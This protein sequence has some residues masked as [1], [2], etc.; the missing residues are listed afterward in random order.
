VDNLILTGPTGSQV[1][2]G[3]YVQAD[4]GPDF[5]T[6]AVLK[7]QFV[8]HPALEGG[9]L[10]YE[11]SGVRR[12]KFP[13]IVPSQS[14]FA[15][16]L[17]GFTSILRQ[18]ARPGA[19]ID[20]QLQGTPTADAVRFDVI[21]GRLDEAYKVGENRAAVRLGTL[22]LDVQ[23]FG[24]WPTWIT[25]ASAASIGTFG[26]LA[27]PGASIL[28]DYLGWAKLD[29]V[30]T[31][32]TY[33]SNAS[34]PQ[35]P[36]TVDVAAWSLAGRSSFNPFLGPGSWM[37]ALPTQSPSF[38]PSLISDV[39]APG[40]KAWALSQLSLGAPFGTA[41]WTQIAIATIGNA[42][43]SAYRGRH[44]AFAAI[45]G[46]ASQVG[47]LQIC[48][49]VISTRNPSGPLASSA[50]VATAMPLQS[51]VGGGSY[52]NGQ[53]ASPAY[54]LLDLGELAV[55]PVGSGLTQDILLRFWGS[56]PTALA[57]SAPTFMFAG[58][59]LHAVDGPAGIIPRGLTLP[60]SGAP[61]SSP[62]FPRVSL[63]SSTR[64]VLL[65]EPSSNLGSA[66]LPVMDGLAYHRGQPPKVTPST[67]QFNLLLAL[68]KNTPSAPIP[69]VHAPAYARVSLSYRPRFAFLKNI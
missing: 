38:T 10:A 54:Q 55:P 62:I 67:V 34:E 52:G 61:G 1:N 69:I 28:G 65:A 2:I 26:S 29:F 16:G 24:Y 21:T 45:G 22:E 50:L 11:Q 17:P 68:R 53:P 6:A 47:V 57:S 32:A 5:D 51:P 41:T 37:Y 66:P 4:P 23:P 35:N 20:L 60:T 25:L 56:R 14:A 49:D 15:G 43:E 13:L 44:R 19:T 42:L 40:G 46:P 3:S 27:I 9:T 12:F 18:L 58:I 59:Y 7:A 36:W 30:S 64:Q 63:D 31:A 39:Y 8:E 33:F 48:L